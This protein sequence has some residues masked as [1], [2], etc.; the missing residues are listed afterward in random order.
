M[1]S[2]AASTAADAANAATTN[3]TFRLAILGRNAFDESLGWSFL[4]RQ[5][6]GDDETTVPGRAPCHNCVSKRHIHYSLYCLADE[7]A[8]VCAVSMHDHQASR[9]IPFAILGLAQRVVKFSEFCRS[10]AVALTEMV[11]DP[12]D[13]RVVILGRCFDLL[14]EAEM[15]LRHV[16][17]EEM[18]PL[19]QA[20]L[21]EHNR[22]QTAE[23]QSIRRLIS[24]TVQSLMAQAHG[25][26]LPV[27]EQYQQFVAAQPS[28]EAAP[29][30]LLRLDRVLSRIANEDYMRPLQASEPDYVARW[31]RDELPPTHEGLQGCMDRLLPTRAGPPLDMNAPATRRTTRRANTRSSA[32]RSVEQE[33]MS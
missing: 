4:D 10:G 9:P 21:E 24:L 8:P 12:P 17:T 18:R 20:S 22:I 15:S 25:A 27:E 14:T 32:A 19:S 2:P 26:P 33:D 30:A 31:D 29:A 3:A 1:S 13:E 23:L 7:S 16:I 11:D 6:P 5:L 28:Y